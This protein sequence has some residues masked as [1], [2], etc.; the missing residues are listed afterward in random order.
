M[1][2][3]Y[4]SECR[5]E[6]LITAGLAFAFLSCHGMNVHLEIRAG[7]EACLIYQQWR[8]CL[9]YFVTT[10]ARSGGWL[11]VKMEYVQLCT[12]YSRAATVPDSLTVGAVVNLTA[13][14]T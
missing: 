4:L 6:T 1:G 3:A 14:E 12:Q 5:A 9:A 2:K 11:Y 10:H 8:G 7:E 13:T